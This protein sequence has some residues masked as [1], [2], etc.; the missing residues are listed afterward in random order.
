ME[1]AAEI[2]LDNF[3]RYRRGEPLKNVVDLAAGY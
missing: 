2:F 1:R 3:E